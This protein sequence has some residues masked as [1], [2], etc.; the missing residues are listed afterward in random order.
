MKC[1]PSE[2]VVLTNKFLMCI[3]YVTE[4]GKLIL[5]FTMSEFI[6]LD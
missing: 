5:N 3:I 4:L 6:N 1:T 2:S